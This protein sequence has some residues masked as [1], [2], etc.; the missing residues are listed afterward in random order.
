MT[1]AE[2]TAPTLLYPAPSL[3]GLHTIRRRNPDYDSQVT[4]YVFADMTLLTMIMH[5]SGGLASGVGL[6]LLVAVAGSAVMLGSQRM[7]LFYAALAT[8]AALLEH[9][10]AALAGGDLAPG[11]SGNYPQVGLFGIGLFAPAFLRNTLA[12]RLR[13]PPAPA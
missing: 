10:S 12:P 6:L 8:I 4:V 5:S 11:G 1:A 7:T 3:V 2:S 9:A 13:A